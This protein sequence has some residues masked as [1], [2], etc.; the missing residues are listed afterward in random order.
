MQVLPNMCMSCSHLHE[1]QDAE[2]AGWLA[3]SCDAYPDQIPADYWSN[4]APHVDPDGSDGGIVW[5]LNE[6]KEDILEVYIGFWGVDV[7]DE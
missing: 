4:G 6:D 7:S 2:D 3:P 1:K 5:E